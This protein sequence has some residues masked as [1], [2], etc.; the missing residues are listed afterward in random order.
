M[1]K[2]MHFYLLPKGSAWINDDR[3]LHEIDEGITDSPDGSL[4]DSVSAITELEDA[5]ADGGMPK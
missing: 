1:S 4:R 3:D 5:R 2:R